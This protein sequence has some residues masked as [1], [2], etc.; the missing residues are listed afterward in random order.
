MRVIRPG[1]ILSIAIPTEG[2]IAWKMDRYLTT[3]RYFKREGLDL[4]YIIARE[5]INACYRLVSLIKHYFPQR[6]EI[7]FPTR[8]PLAHCNL[9]YA[10]TITINI[11]EPGT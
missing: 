9:L 5:H 11:A 3:R 8:I 1:G 6:R 7:W 2:G 10:T 4:D